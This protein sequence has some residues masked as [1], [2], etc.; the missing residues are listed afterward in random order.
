MIGERSR[1]L[2]KDLS[3]LSLTVYTLQKTATH[4]PQIKTP[5]GGRKYIRWYIWYAVGDCKYEVV[6]GFFFF[7]KK[8]ATGELEEKAG[9]KI[10]S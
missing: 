6:E 5:R 9:S 1:S 7:L 8:G 4:V 3:K 2:S 10:N